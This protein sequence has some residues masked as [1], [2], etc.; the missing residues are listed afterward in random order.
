MLYKVK[1][2]RGKRVIV[3]NDQV[4][5]TEAQ[6]KQSILDKGFSPNMQAIILRSIKETKEVDD[7]RAEL[8][9]L[10]LAPETIEAYISGET[11]K[12]EVKVEAVAEA[13]DS[14][15]EVTKKSRKRRVTKS[16]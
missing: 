12:E 5:T 11:V 4:F 13:N 10:K 1:G 7:V 6:V 14:P 16:K 3:W 8:T 2:K 15:K 9:K